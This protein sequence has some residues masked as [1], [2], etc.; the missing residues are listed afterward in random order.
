MYCCTE[1]ELEHKYWINVDCLL[2]AYY[3]PEIFLNVI[4][5]FCLPNP[6]NE[7]I[8]QGLSLSLLYE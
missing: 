7:P 2:S 6:H 4:Y 5:V 3:V 1:L 8:K